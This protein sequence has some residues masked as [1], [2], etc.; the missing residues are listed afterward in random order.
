MWW[1]TC[2]RMP[3]T[4]GVQSQYAATAGRT[5]NFQV[6]VC[7]INAGCRGHAAVDRAPYVPCSWSAEPDDGR[8]AVLDEGFA[9]ATEPELA[10]RTNGRFPA[11][12][13]TLFPSS[14][15]STCASQGASFTE[16]CARTGAPREGM[17]RPRVGCQPSCSV[18]VF[19]LRHFQR[20]K[21]G[22]R[23]DGRRTFF[24]HRGGELLVLQQ[25]AVHLLTAWLLAA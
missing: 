1:S 16:S 10:D 25:S 12:A 22:F 23:A 20:R 24:G 5:E 6:A 8:A 2:R 9:F 13:V 15:G 14:T 17:N 11:S 18:G 19:S 21:D 3:C 7:L 4:V